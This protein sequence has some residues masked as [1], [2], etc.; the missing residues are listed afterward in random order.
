[1]L[2]ASVN[3]TVDP[4][5]T[6][7][8]IV[9][10]LAAALLGGMRSFGIAVA[11]GIGVSMLQSLIQYSGRYDW[12]P[13]SGSGPLPG[14]RDVLPFALIVLA[15]F[16]RGNSLPARGLVQQTRMPPA[17]ETSHVGRLLAT[18]GTMSVVGLLTLG[19]DWRLAIINSTVGALIAL[20]FV[21]LTGFVGQISLAQMALA[22][23]CGFTLAKLSDSWGVPFPLA[24][25]AGAV[26][27][28]LVG[29]IAGIPALRVR[30]ANLAVV[31]L[32]AAIAIEQFVFRNPVW[33]DGGQ[34]AR[35]PSPRVLGLEFGPNDPGSLSVIGYHG[36]GKLPNPWFGVFCVVVLL[37]TIHMVAN[38]RRGATGR[39]FLAVRSNERA[40][41]AA[42][43]SVARTKLLAFG[44][45]ALV[46]GIGGALSGYRFGSV[47]PEAF[48]VLSSLTFLAFAYVGG[49]TSVVGAAVAGLVV[50]GGIG[51]TGMRLWFDIG[52][53][54]TQ[55]LAGAGLIAV[56]ASQPDGIAGALYSL[57]HRRRRTRSRH[58]VTPITGEPS[59]TRLDQP[60][61]GEAQHGDTGRRIE[62]Q[63]AP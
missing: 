23:V 32:A 43:I 6:T 22:G 54:Y 19:P 10:A 59:G 63:H 13:R 17:P 15:L 30:G 40:A 7:L 48:G 45:S 36:D 53:E 52:D 27:A 1:V 5:T 37:L 41:A 26:A 8:L 33:A 31:T 51:T 18:V 44:L 38:L 50:A 24:P 21:V 62:V 28:T 42:G 14:V 4:T 34:G 56:M 20:S 29:V 46:A 2:V 16:L 39:R 11:A 25:I 9:P 55:L 61:P 49:I 3:G 47:T 12:F 58:E 35:V 60:L 57:V